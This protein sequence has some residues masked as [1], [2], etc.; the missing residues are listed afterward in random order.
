MNKYKPKNIQNEYKGR[1]EFNVKEE[2]KKK[3]QKVEILYIDTCSRRENNNEKR[4][5]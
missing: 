5:R 2:G 3:R 4:K 1:S